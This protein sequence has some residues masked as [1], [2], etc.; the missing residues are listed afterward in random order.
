LA[1]ERIESDSDAFDAT[2]CC[3]FASRH[4]GFQIAHSIGF[5]VAVVWRKAQ[6]A[7]AVLGAHVLHL[8]MAVLSR[9]GTAQGL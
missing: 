4:F 1:I 3:M 5:F 7:S 8:V 6:H 9:I 2:Q